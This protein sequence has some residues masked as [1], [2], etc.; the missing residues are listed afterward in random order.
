MFILNYSELEFKSHFRHDKTTG[1][2]LTLDVKILKNWVILGPMGN[3]QLALLTGH[4]E[5]GGF[6]FRVTTRIEDQNQA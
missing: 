5:A 3:K 1:Q 4:L 2:L 6:G